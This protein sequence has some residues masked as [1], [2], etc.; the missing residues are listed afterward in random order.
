MTEERDVGLVISIIGLS[1][2]IQKRLGSALSVHGIGVTEYLV[3]NQLHTSPAK[4]LQRSELAAKVGLTPSG[5]TRLIN[6]MEKMGLV[7]KEE[8]PRDARV[9]LVALSAAGRQVFEDAQVSF[10]QAAGALF[11]RLGAPQ[12]D[13]LSELL[14]SVAR[15]IR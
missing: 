9:S 11:E 3:L 12:L 15:D 1:G 4:T 13:A 10:A 6:P 5:I 7:E 2:S 14:Q 8:N